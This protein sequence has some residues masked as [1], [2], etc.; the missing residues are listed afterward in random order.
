MSREPLQATLFEDPPPY[1][2]A[3]LETKKKRATKRLR[4]SS[5]KPAG[6]A[7]VNRSMPPDGKVASCGVDR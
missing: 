2:P 7:A 5:G 1:K 6:P 4:R 3:W